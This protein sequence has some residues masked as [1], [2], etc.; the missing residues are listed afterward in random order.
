LIICVLNTEEKIACD[1]ES[2]GIRSKHCAVADSQFLGKR[3]VAV[4]KKR[5]KFLEIDLKI[6]I[7]QTNFSLADF[8]FYE[9]FM[10][11]FEK[12]CMHR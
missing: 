7:F 10:L 9:L 4:D 12:N 3:D 6:E 8:R 1:H 5:I 11:F 2:G